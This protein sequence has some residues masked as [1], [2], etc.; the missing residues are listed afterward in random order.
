MKLL[1]ALREET[2]SKEKKQA[3]ADAL[4]VCDEG[5]IEQLVE[6]EVSHETMA[7]LSLIPQRLI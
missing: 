4:G 2:A 1:E 7:A 6:I 3:L 5:L